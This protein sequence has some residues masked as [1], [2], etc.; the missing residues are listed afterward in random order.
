MPP[1]ET[2][3]EI[4]GWT[5][6][7]IDAC[8]GRPAGSEACLKSGQMIAEALRPHC[9]RVDLH[10][11]HCQPRAFITYEAASAGVAAL[12]VVPLFFGHVAISAA[13]LGLIALVE[14]IQF[15]FY[16]EV[17]DWMFPKARCTNVVGTIEPKGP[18]KRQIVV[19][20]H[21][22]TA[23][24]FRYL[25]LSPLLYLGLGL[26]H[27]IATYG[28]PAL[29]GAALIAQATTGWSLP[30]AWAKGL[31]IFAFVPAAIFTTYFTRR[32]VPGAGDNLASSGIAVRTAKVIRE[33][34]QSD[35]E[36]LAGTRLLFLSFD[37]EESGLRGSRAYVREH[38]AALKAV[39]TVMLNLESFYKLKDLCVLTQD[40]N[41]FRRLSRRVADLWID[42]GRVRGLKVA[43]MKLFYGLGATDAA[44]F[45]K[46]GIE[47]ATLLAVPQSPFGAGK[48]VYHTRDDTPENL[49]PAVIEAA[50]D[51]TL[52]MVDR[53]VREPAELPATRAAA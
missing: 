40:L 48:I 39:P 28:V 26:W 23:F 41:G 29:L 3:R 44:E 49:E 18:V 10:E 22:D 38:L 5:Q 52:A 17:V 20:G 53:L 37:A 32:P 27:K 14:I 34:L 35:P 7:V 31:A 16:V 1:N 46:E 43:P 47:A 24:E 12:A 25:R 51:L 8:G 42:E 33:R 4:L 36:A 21:H 2:S 19:S 11:F 6:R 13:L 50:A 9:D 15:G 45:A 30:D